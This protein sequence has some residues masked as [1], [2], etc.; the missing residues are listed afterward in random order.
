MIQLTICL[1]LMNVPFSKIN[2]SFNEENFKLLLNKYFKYISSSKK[3]QYV[4]FHLINLFNLMNYYNKHVISNE[5]IK[6]LIH[7]EIQ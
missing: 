5:K 6:F 2:L 4:D 7:S 1:N 3:A